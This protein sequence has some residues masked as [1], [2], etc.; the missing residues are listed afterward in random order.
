MT[1]D[2]RGTL[3]GNDWRLG[4]SALLG[5]A[6]DHQQQ[7]SWLGALGDRSA[8]VQREVQL[9]AAAWRGPWQARARLASGSFQRQMQRSLLLGG[10]QDHVGSRLSGDYLGLAFELAHRLQAGPLVLRPYLSGDYVRVAN[11]GFAEAGATGFGLQARAWDG[12]RWQA[13][14]GLRAER[15]WR[16][17][18][19]QWTLDAR[20][21]WQR[22]L[23]NAGTAF[24]ASFTGLAQ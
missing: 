20:M 12:R 6:I 4:D 19:V 8:G 24:D 5:L 11:D 3:V 1:L 13:G 7:V 9:Y 17:G 2:S 10:L 15:S 14:A 18:D 23:A 22:T 21:E 16:V